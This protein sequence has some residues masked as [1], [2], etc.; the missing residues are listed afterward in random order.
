LQTEL[1][2]VMKFFD[3]NFD[4]VAWQRAIK[5]GLDD[6]IK[7]YPSRFHQIISW[8]IKLVAFLAVLCFRMWYFIYKFHLHLPF[9]PITLYYF[10][11]FS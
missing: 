4:V 3:R 1:E 11:L 7:P 10:L 6:V 5:F 8:E 2:E 9:S